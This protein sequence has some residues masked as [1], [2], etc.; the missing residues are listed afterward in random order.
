MHSLW[1]FEISYYLCGWLRLR[2]EKI[3]KVQGKQQMHERKMGRERIGVK[4]PSKMDSP[5]RRADD[6][7]AFRRVKVHAKLAGGTATK[8]TVEN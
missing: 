7:V 1:A 3:L 2:E 4:T 8:K 5:K 6:E